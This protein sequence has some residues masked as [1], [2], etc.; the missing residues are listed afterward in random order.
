M[1][2]LSVL[3]ISVMIFPMLFGC[4]DK[5]EIDK[6]AFVSTIGLDTFE[7]IDKNNVSVYEL[8]STIY[9]CT[10]H[11]EKMLTWLQD[12]IQSGRLQTVR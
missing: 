7:F 4:Y 8:I 2:K 10:F 3:I 9:L 1:K 5:V 11:Q 6:R 12:G